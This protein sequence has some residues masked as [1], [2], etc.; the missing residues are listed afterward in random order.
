MVRKLKYS[1]D[2]TLKTI[3][4]SVNIM[5]YSLRTTL[6]DKVIAQTLLMKMGPQSVLGLPEE[7][8]LIDI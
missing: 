6:R 3:I 2:N 7:N 8:I 1:V 5:V 4:E